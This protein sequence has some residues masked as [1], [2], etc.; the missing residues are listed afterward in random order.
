MNLC[1]CCILLSGVNVVYVV[2]EIIVNYCKWKEVFYE[3]AFNLFFFFT[4]KVCPFCLSSLV[5][6]SLKSSYLPL[7][8]NFSFKNCWAKP[9]VMMLLKQISVRK[10]VTWQPFLHRG[11][12]QFKSMDVWQSRMQWVL[13]FLVLSSCGRR[14]NGDV[15]SSAGNIWLNQMYWEHCSK[16]DLF[17]SCEASCAIS[18]FAPLSVTSRCKHE[19]F[20][21]VFEAHLGLQDQTSAPALGWQ[22]SSV[23]ACAP[24]HFLFA[25]NCCL[26]SSIKI[27]QG[28]SRF[29]FP[30]RNTFIMSRS[31]TLYPQC[32]STVIC[33][34]Q[35]V[36]SCMPQKNQRSLNF[37]CNGRC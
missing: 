33:T 25:D 35:H 37:S 1:I 24:R 14:R 7:V 27:V 4:H 31:L 6:S 18:P 34:N 20:G 32:C 16:E 23:R 11:R 10:F 21:F 19:L 28:S 3:R 29:S 26:L 12:T 8:L 17:Q 5:L 15:C 13:Y 22:I 36:F 30:F 9:F 2:R